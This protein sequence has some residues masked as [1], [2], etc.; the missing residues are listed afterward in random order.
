VGAPFGFKPDIHTAPTFERQNILPH[1][2]HQFSRAATKFSFALIF[3]VLSK[4]LCCL[5]LADG[6]PALLNFALWVRLWGS[7]RI[8]TLL[9]LLS[10]KIFCLT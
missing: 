7:N 1:M 6:T 4:I 3:R 5:Q 10:A 2:I 9:Q 8:F